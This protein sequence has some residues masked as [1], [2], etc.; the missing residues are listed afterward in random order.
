MVADRVTRG[1]PVLDA[2]KMETSL[3]EGGCHWVQS[4]KKNLLFDVLVTKRSGQ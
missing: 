2:Q 3:T 1:A 4:V